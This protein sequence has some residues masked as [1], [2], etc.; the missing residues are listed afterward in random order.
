MNLRFFEFMVSGAFGALLIC[1]IILGLGLFLWKQRSVSEAGT[2]RKVLAFGLGIPVLLIA[3]IMTVS[4]V[5]HSGKYVALNGSLPPLRDFSVEAPKQGSIEKLPVVTFAME[6]GR[7]FKLQL[8]PYAAPN[9]VYSFIELTQQDFFDGFIFRR[10]EKSLIEA[11][12]PTLPIIN[13]LLPTP[14]YNIYGEFEGNG[15]PNPMKFD[16]GDIGLAMQFG[17]TAAPAAFFIMNEDA[18]GFTGMMPAFGSVI[19]GMEIVDD[20]RAGETVKIA[21]NSISPEPLVIKSVSVETFG[22]DYPAPVKLPDT[23]L[24]VQLAMIGAWVEEGQAVLEKYNSEM[25][26]AM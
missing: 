1:L 17:F 5:V 3:A 19:E 7:Q 16:R 22:A 18:S 15:Y 20:I 14:G 6:D 12:D 21:G 4:S 8:N 24:R 2:G 10:L 13:D 23:P 26:S 25:R 9:T 11:A